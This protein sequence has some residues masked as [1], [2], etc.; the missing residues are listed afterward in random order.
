MINGAKI[1]GI[2][3]LG[4]VMP[5]DTVQGFQFLDHWWLIKC[6]YIDVIDAPL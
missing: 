2:Y 6:A 3:F 4:Y 1:K 5:K